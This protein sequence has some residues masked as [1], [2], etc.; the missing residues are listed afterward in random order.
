M[1]RFTKKKPFLPIVLL[2]ACGLGIVFFTRK[3][4]NPNSFTIQTKGKKVKVYLEKLDTN[5]F[6]LHADTYL[7]PQLQL[8]S[9]WKLNY[10]VYQLQHA[11]VNGDG[12]ED[13]AVG[14]IKTTR[15]DPIRRKRL[16]IFKLFDG[17]I[18]PLWLGSR[19]GQPL[20]DFRLISQKPFTLIRTIEKE[21]DGSYL[22]AEYRWRGF[23]LEFQQYLQRNTSLAEAKQRL[24][25]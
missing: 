25:N 4:T 15:F 13:M 23:G 10:P 5:A 22:L 1:G 16:F 18:R 19:V 7:G 3:A 14:V 21:R 8:A 12:L 17:Y 11:D 6:I 9:S 24:N 20:E 2:I